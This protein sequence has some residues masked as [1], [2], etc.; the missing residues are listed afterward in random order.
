MRGGGLRVVAAQRQPGEQPARAKIQTEQG[1]GGGDL[2]IMGAGMLVPKACPPCTTA[3]REWRM[4]EG[5]GGRRH[6]VA[7]P[8]AP[9]PK[10][11]SPTATSDPHAPVQVAAHGYSWKQLFFERNLQETLEQ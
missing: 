11:P 9:L 5:G 7:R 4:G 8:P 6:Q 1:G 2:M 10:C 3:A